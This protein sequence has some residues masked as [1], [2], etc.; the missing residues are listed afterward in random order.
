MELLGDEGPDGKGCTANVI[1]IKGGIMYISNAGDS[2]SVLATRNLAIDLSIDHKPDND[3]EKTRIAKA[4]GSVTGGRV[5]GNLNLSR[6]LGDLRYKKNTAL[7]PEEQMISASP[8]VFRQPI[9]KDFDF[10]VMGCDGI[11]DRFS[12]QQ[13]VDKIYNSFK[14]KPDLKLVQHAENLVDSLVSP[15]IAQNEGTGCD[16]MTCIIIKF[17]HNK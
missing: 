11:Y 8:D 2:R 12:S 17:E 3:K 14:E 7:K 1:L 13:I 16:N 10:V 15:D 4:G 5:E 6:A 9:S